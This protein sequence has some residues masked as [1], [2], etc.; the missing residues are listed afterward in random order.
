VAT[1]NVSTSQNLTLFKTWFNGVSP[2]EGDKLM[3]NE[4][5]PLTAADKKD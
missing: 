4:P 2:V 3:I 5:L 1:V